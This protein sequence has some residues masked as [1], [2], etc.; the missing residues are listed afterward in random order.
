[1]VAQAELREKV[2]G[3][4]G[5]NGVRKAEEPSD[6]VTFFPGHAGILAQK[7]QLEADLLNQFQAD[8]VVEKPRQARHT[9]CPATIAEKVWKSGELVKGEK[10]KYYSSTHGDWFDTEVVHVQ[11]NEG[12]VSRVD[13][14]CKT[15]ADLS[16]ITKEMGPTYAPG[17]RV[18]YWSKSFNTWITGTVQKVCQ[19][20]TCDLDVK[21]AAVLSKLRPW[22]A[23][24]P[25]AEESDEVKSRSRRTKEVELPEAVSELESGGERPAPGRET[26][27]ELPA[28]TPSTGNSEVSTAVS[29]APQ[30][31]YRDWPA[32]KIFLGTGL[33]FAVK[34]RRARVREA[35][36]TDGT[37]GLDLGELILETETFDP[38]EP[39]IRSQLSEALGGFTSVEAMTGFSGGLNDGV[40]F[41]SGDEGELVLK[42][43]KCQRIAS[44]VPTEAENLEKVYLEHP[45]ICSDESLAFPHRIFSCMLDGA[46]KYDLIVMH[47]VPGE[48]LTEVIYQKYWKK[49][50]TSLLRIF[51]CCGQQLAI[52]HSRYQKQHGDFQPSNIFYDDVSEGI[53]FIDVGGMGVPTMDND[54]EHF[55]SAMKLLKNAY[56]PTLHEELVEAFETGYNACGS[57]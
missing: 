23:E 56:G 31:P 57:V 45:E 20:G 13:L 54:V 4:E 27:P 41:C 6:Y 8:T 14:T 52:F 30:I 19:D 36:G 7:A 43:V 38:S 22:T 42:L 53:Y 3:L 9:K 40:W 55:C 11:E 37:S 34:G 24:K 17:D 44:N 33:E 18:W 51:E 28:V 16:R 29:V 2:P 10:V 47:K 35:R 50:E 5:P 25:E 26:D 48:R 1:M 49:Q 21:Q 32:E 15:R 39:R 46:K 12:F